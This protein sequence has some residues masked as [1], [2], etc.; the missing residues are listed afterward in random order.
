MLVLGEAPGNEPLPVF[1]GREASDSDW[2]SR[3]FTDGSAA[4]KGAVDVGPFT[5][6]TTGVRIT[7]TG[8]VYNLG[9]GA[10]AAYW[11]G[12]D[13]NGDLNRSPLRWKIQKHWWRPRS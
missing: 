12:P 1:E 10:N 2:S 11:T 6:G 13:I 4:F 9:S 7:N 8:T 5:T 3:I